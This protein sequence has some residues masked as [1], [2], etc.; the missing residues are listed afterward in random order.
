MQTYLQ[1]VDALPCDETVNLILV[2]EVPPEHFG[3]LI[4]GMFNLHRNTTTG[5]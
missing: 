2:V 3:R 1:D 4:H 5:L